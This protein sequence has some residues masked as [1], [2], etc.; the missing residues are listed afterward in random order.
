MKYLDLQF[1]K[2]DALSLWGADVASSAPPAS[3]SHA[4]GHSWGAPILGSIPCME[5]NGSRPIIQAI[6]LMPR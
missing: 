1:S 2:P 4:P 3:P 6:F 5:R